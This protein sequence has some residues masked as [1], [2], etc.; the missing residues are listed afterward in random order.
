GS[1]ANG[2]TRYKEKAEDWSGVAEVGAGRV[3][4]ESGSSRVSQ[5]QAGSRQ[6]AGKGAHG[7]NTPRP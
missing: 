3:Q 6:V 1:V 2:Q 5:D 7:N 4:A